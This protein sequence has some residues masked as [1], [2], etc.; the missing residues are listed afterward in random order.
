[1]PQTTTS[2]AQSAPTS[3]TA[4]SPS[5]RTPATPSTRTPAAALAP[6]NNAAIRHPPIQ[7][8]APPPIS[9]E[10]LG[11]YA[12]DA[13]AADERE[14]TFFAKQFDAQ[15][16]Y[17]GIFSAIVVQ[18][19][20]QTYPLLQ[21][22]N[23]SVSAIAINVGFFGALIVSLC[24][25]IMA[26]QCKA[27]LDGYEAFRLAGCDSTSPQ[28]LTA[29]CRLREYRYQGLTKYHVLFAARSA[30]P[31]LIYGAFVF[32]FIGLIVLLLTLHKPIA[33]AAIV[34]LGTF[35]VGHLMTSITSCFSPG[36]PY[37]T[38]MGSFM[39]AGYHGVR[40]GKRP[41]HE[42]TQ[43]VELEDV[44]THQEQLDKDILKWLLGNAKNSAIRELA[45]EELLSRSGNIVP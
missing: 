39:A 23:P 10:L 6:N 2:P 24:T 15:L 26:L 27:W 20:P 17:S 8:S 3:A 30:G 42:L 21:T 41:S 12:S 37:K 11:A 40:L 4:G 45:R 36:A 31:M 38:P 28:S 13:S 34:F 9:L 33:I 14:F 32:F 18:L 35:L 19:I 29:A 7:K 22:E 43:K 44:E 5:T 1:M 16:V 25:A